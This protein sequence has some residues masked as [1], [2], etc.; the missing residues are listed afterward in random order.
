VTGEK[1]EDSVTRL[2]L[3]DQPVTEF[4][5]DSLA[6]R[7]RADQRV[8]FVFG[9]TMLSRW[10]K[11]LRDKEC[12]QPLACAFAP[13]HNPV[14]LLPTCLALDELFGRPYVLFRPAH[15]FDSRV[16]V[17]MNANQQGAAFESL[18]RRA[19]ERR[20]QAQSDYDDAWR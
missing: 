11:V 15:R 2:S 16:G 5:E 4:G 3:F 12:G 13:I 1:K 18:L 10:V 17:L 14:K 20:G 6:R 8:Y 9:E 19:A 7:R